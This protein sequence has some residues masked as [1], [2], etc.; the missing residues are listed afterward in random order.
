MLAKP[1]KS[2]KKPK[3]NRPNGAAWAMVIFSVIIILSMIITS[4]RF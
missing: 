2:K 1:K 4:F 3:N